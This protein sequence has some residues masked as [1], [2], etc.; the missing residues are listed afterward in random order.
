MQL[1][2]RINIQLFVRPC[3]DDTCLLCYL[4]FQHLEF[5]DCKAELIELKLL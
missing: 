2:C 1:I 5:V 4:A 3:S